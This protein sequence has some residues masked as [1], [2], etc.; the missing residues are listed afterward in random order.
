MRVHRTNVYVTHRAL[1]S[2]GRI[3]VRLGPRTCLKTSDVRYFLLPLPGFKLRLIDIPANSLIYSDWAI[4]W[5]KYLENHTR[6][7][8]RETKLPTLGQWKTSLCVLQIWLMTVAQ[9]FVTSAASIGV[10][11]SITSS[12]L[13]ENSV[14][15]PLLDRRAP[16]QRSV[17]RSASIVSYD[18]V[19]QF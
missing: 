13:N 18:R 1:S 17:R 4:L 16:A 10:I 12:I 7:R 14:F 9:N 19:G 6:E 3:S 15:F 5:L 8:E 11:G 2:K